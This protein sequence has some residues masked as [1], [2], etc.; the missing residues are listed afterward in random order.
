L[1]QETQTWNMKAHHSPFKRLQTNRQTGQKPYVPDLSIREHNKNK[2]GMYIHNH[3]KVT[4]KPSEYFADSNII[5]GTQRTY[6]L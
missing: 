4:F 5:M 2:V 3:S 6:I 1:S